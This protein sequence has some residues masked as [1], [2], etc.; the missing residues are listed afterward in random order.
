MIAFFTDV[1][2]KLLIVVIPSGLSLLPLTL[3]WKKKSLT[4]LTNFTDY[5]RQILT[6]KAAE[7]SSFP[8]N[9]WNNFT[10]AN[11]EGSLTKS[12]HLNVYLNLPHTYPHL[13]L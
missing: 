2:P 6:Q 4:M 5:Q 8:D 3:E 13:I 12:E 11:K 1:S 7:I 9:F 10:F